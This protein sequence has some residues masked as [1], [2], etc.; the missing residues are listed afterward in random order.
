MRELIICGQREDKERKEK[1]QR[2]ETGGGD[3]PGWKVIE[4]V[5]KFS[6]E[7][8]KERLKLGG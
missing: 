8:G 5:E 7:V 1:I 4:K 2:V 6:N 3:C